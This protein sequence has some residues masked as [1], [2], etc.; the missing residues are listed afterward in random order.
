MKKLLL[1]IAILLANVTVLV[2]Q[3]NL[4]I[5]AGY[6]HATWGFGNNDETTW[7]SGAN[8]GVTT[9]LG[10]GEKVS[11]RPGIY[12]SAKGYGHNDDDVPRVRLNYVEVPLLAVFNIK[13]GDNVN[14]EFQAGGYMAYG[15][16]GKTKVQSAVEYLPETHSVSPKYV[17]E[18]SF[19]G[20]CKEDKFD[21]GVNA[22]FGVNIHR[23]YI[24]VAYDFGL[25]VSCKSSHQCFMAN[26][27][28]RL[29]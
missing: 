7:I 26:V 18:K 16:G 25:R 22:G 29:L 24:G 21:A 6:N 27:G 14:F 23:F 3:P 15:I 17:K 12:F 9:D 1:I 4:S 2:A 13:G 28:Y 11:F 20:N 8:F 10:K 19:A 5:R